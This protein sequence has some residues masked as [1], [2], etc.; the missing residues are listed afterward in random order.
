MRY[1]LLLTTMLLQLEVFA[2]QDTA[3]MPAT[4]TNATVYYGYG[5]ELTHKAKVAVNKSTKFIVIDKLSTYLSNN[6][7]YLSICI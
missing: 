5:A 4:I 6:G 7:Q 1:L 3:M 2:Q